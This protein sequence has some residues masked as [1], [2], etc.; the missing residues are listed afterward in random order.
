MTDIIERLRWAVHK[1][2]V[3]D[4]PSESDTCAKAA[5]EIERLRAALRGLVDHHVGTCDAWSPHETPEV[6]AALAAI[7][8]ESE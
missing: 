5:D 1:L 7:T 2:D 3:L 6:I 8:G 4:H